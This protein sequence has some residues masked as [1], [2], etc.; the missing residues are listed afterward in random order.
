L[1]ISKSRIHHPSDFEVVK[2]TIMTTVKDCVDRY[3]ATVYSAFLLH[4]F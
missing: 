1:T 2:P 3:A 4:Q